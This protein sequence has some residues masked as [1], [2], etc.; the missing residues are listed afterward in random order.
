[1]HYYSHRSNISSTK[2]TKSYLK[3][4][5]ARTPRIA[6]NGYP[7]PPPPTVVHASHPINNELPNYYF[8]YYYYYFLSS[9]TARALAWS[10][11]EP[12]DL[13]ASPAFVERHETA[14]AALGEAA[15][16]AKLLLGRLI[17]VG[18]TPGG[19]RVVPDAAAAAAAAVEREWFAVV[20]R[21]ET[22]MGRR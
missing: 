19:R 15:R 13:G 8:Y 20:E 3:F 1:M 6:S 10:G 4:Q 17:A 18:E 14:E 9:Q 22:W 11:Q 16:R 12:R 5:F 21:H 7:L 2:I